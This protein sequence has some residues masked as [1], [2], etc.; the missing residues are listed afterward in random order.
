M[1]ATVGVE[2]LLDAH[3]STALDLALESD[4]L[5]VLSLLQGA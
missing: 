4:A 3:G 5:D 1:K 2:T